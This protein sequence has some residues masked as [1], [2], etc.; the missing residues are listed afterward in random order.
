MRQ[1]LQGRHDANAACR[2]EG[3]KPKGGTP[4]S[5]FFAKAKSRPNQ[6]KKNLKNG[7]LA[8]GV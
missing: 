7:D 4:K 6:N 5:P 8:G 2:S 3:M 1:G